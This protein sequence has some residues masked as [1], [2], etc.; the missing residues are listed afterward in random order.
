[1]KLRTLEC[2]CEIATNGFNYSRAAKALN[3]TQPAITRQIQLLEQELGFA[4][5]ERLRNRAVSL[6]PA[7]Q[8]AFARALKIVN[9]SRELRAIKDDLSSELSGK[10]TI[11]TTEYNARYT[12]LPVIKRFRSDH[13][14]VALSI[15]SVDPSMAA[16]MVISGDADLAVC[17]TTPQSVEHLLSYKWIEVERAVIAPPGH[18]LLRA[19]RLSLQQ[20]AAYPL[21][22]YDSRLSAGKHVLD[23][24]EEQGISIQIALSSTTADAIK[25]YVAAGMGVGII[26]AGAFDKHHDIGIRA[27]DA[28]RLFRRTDIFLML[29]KGYVPRT[30][31]QRFISILA[32]QSELATAPR[33]DA[34]LSR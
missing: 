3:A 34:A 6:T 1:M 11:A 22:L 10:L 7:G 21:V 24:F 32:P 27:I 12:L 14:L 17:S 19:K 31:S 26:Q 16:N 2:F 29:R 23:A 4:V 33:P 25:S 18:P 13:P 30:I 8:T 20:I 15:V 9:D 28:S 5:F